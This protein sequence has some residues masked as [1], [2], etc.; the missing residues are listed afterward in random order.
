ML[1]IIRCFIFI[2]KHIFI[3]LS[4]ILHAVATPL[5]AYS[6]ILSADI[7]RDSLLGRA[8]V[9]FFQGTEPKGVQSVRKRLLYVRK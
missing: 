6:D 5:R 3:N 2:L 1:E 7:C 4:A 9:L 8:N